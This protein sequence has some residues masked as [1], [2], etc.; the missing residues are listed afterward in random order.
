[1]NTIKCVITFYSKHTLHTSISNGGATEDAI[2]LKRSINSASTYPG[3]MLQL[4]IINKAKL[5][6][7]LYCVCVI[8]VDK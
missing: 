2:D 6:L 8:D 1:M 4:V 7:K 3:Y 5:L